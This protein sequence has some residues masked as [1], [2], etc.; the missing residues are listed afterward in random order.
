MSSAVGGAC[1]VMLSLGE[2]FRADHCTA[3]DVSTVRACRGGLNI[4]RVVVQ[5]TGAS[6][7]RVD[8]WPRA[9]FAP[10]TS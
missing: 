4:L 8:G 5:V 3:F 6:S 7:L 9:L 1:I 10:S 2:A